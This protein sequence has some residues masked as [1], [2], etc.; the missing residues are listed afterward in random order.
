MKWREIGLA[1]SLDFNQLQLIESRSN[2]PGTRKREMFKLAVKQGITWKNLI[3]ALCAIG[4]RSIATN[5]CQIFDIPMNIS[6]EL[7]G[8]TE[9]VCYNYFCCSSWPCIE[10][11]LYSGPLWNKLKCP[12]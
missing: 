1:L 10:M 11:L 6:R 8:D 12:D 5:V 2:K 4:E 9:K 7:S 3:Q